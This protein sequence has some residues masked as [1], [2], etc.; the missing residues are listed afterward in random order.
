M[1]Y[2]GKKN[3]AFERGMEKMSLAYEG[4]YYDA[5]A[6]ARAE[7]E[8]AANERAWQNALAWVIADSER[9][10]IERQRRR[11]RKL[12]EG[13]RLWARWRAERAWN[14]STVPESQ[15]QQLTRDIITC[16]RNFHGGISYRL[17][18]LETLKMVSASSIF[19]EPQYYRNG[20]RAKARVMD[21]LCKVDKQ[22]VRFE[23]DMLDPFRGMTTSQVMEKAIDDAL[24]AD[25]EGTLAWAV[26]LRER[27]LMRLNPQVILVRAA[28]HPG[29]LAYT[30]EHPGEFAKIAQ[31]VMLRG[32]DVTNQVQ[33]W[34]ASHGTKRGIPAVLKRSW[35]KRVGSMGAYAMAKYGN[36][37]IGLVDVVRICHAKG[38]LVDTLMREG[39]VPMPEGQDTWERLR[40][41]GMG[42]GEILETI[43]MP[44]MALLRNLRGIF[45]EVDDP[46][47]REKALALLKRGVRGGKQF[48][49]R[50]LSAW[51]AAEAERA[52]WTR[53]VQDALE[54]C[55]VIACENLPALPGRSAFLA[56]VSGSMWGTCTSAYG[57]MTM[58]EIANLSCVIGAMRAEEGVVFPFAD[59]IERV[60]VNKAG[61]I[62]EQARLV[63]KVGCGCGTEDPFWIFLR[64]AIARRE[65]W[66]NIFVYS[67]MQAG[68]GSQELCFDGSDQRV[69]AN[70]MIEAYRQMVNPKVNVYSIQVG[71]YTNALIPEYGYRTTLLSGWTG[72]ELVFADAVNRTWDEIES[73]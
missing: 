60:P 43:R 47:A 13:E 33:Y 29:R 25:Y 28:T 15:R 4:R 11:E 18:P 22:F 63:G 19:G 67:D 9:R 14:H 5:R 59:W 26:E 57:T 34:L 50:Y 1:S 10:R 52:P 36:A 42:W 16:E 31:R 70:T 58:A 7:R 44:H 71:G 39:H 46:K 48:P 6:R 45:S 41:S 73:K 49:F 38:P 61:N 24:D 65:H 68:Y 2:Q 55:M 54:E 3:Y 51:K 23:L 72:K 40:A 66:D 35:A 21:G 64:E 69:S 53:Q 20:A 27:Y 30:Q 8:K 17:S 56:D 32:D 12:A 37:G 62:L